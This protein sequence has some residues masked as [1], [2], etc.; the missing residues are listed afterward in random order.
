VERLIGGPAARTALARMSA[1]QPEPA[2]PAPARADLERTRQ[3][4]SQEADKLAETGRTLRAEA[5][6]LARL[7]GADMDG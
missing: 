6:T 1:D 5:D 7:G 2:G 4:L 3:H